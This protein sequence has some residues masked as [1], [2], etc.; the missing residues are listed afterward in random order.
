[1]KRS[2]FAF[3]PGVKAEDLQYRLISCLKKKPD[4]III[5]IG[6]NDSSYKS[7]DLIYKEFLN[8]KQIIHKHHPN[9]KNIVS[10]PTI[11][12]YKQEA[13]SILKR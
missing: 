13:N 10:S 12:T 1:M 7:E 11:R 5:R 4:N 2:K 8:V 6:T 3:F 9:C